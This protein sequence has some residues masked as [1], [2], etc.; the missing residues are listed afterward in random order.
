MLGKILAFVYYLLPDG[1]SHGVMI[2]FCCMITCGF[3]CQRD[4]FVANVVSS[5]FAHKQYVCDFLEI[6]FLLW[7]RAF[8]L[9]P[10]FLCGCGGSP[11]SPP[12]PPSPPGVR[13][14]LAG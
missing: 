6:V 7:P 13:C 11:V 2:F 9:S 4:F 12:R 10:G 1:S 5:I 3:C 8:R 14:H